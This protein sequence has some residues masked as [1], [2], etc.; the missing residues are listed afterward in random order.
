MEA[1]PNT[2]DFYELENDFYRVLLRTTVGAIVFHGFIILS[3]LL[4]AKL[5]P[6]MVRQNFSALS[7]LKGTCMCGF[8]SIFELI[9]LVWSFPR[10]DTQYFFIYGMQ[11]LTNVQSYMGTL[12]RLLRVW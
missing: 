1:S 9:A 12:L 5:F 2:V 8:F 3:A 6:S 4:R 11:L 10:K 7:V